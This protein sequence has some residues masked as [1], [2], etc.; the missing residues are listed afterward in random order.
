MGKSQHKRL[1]PTLVFESLAAG[2]P[3]AEAR[4]KALWENSPQRSAFSSIAYAQGAA[5]AFGLRLNMHLVSRD[6]IDEAGAFIWWRQRLGTRQATLPPFTQYSAV[7][8]RKTPTPAAINR[9]QAPLEALLQGLKARYKGLLLLLDVADPRPAQWRHWRV[10]PLFTYRLDPA[11]RQT[12]WSTTTRRT[13]RKYGRVFKTT[14]S[15]D[16]AQT[17]IRLCEASYQRHGRKLPASEG[18]LLRLIEHLGPSV[19][20]F[21]TARPDAAHPEA[22]LAVLHDGRTAHYW[23]AGST[24]GPSMT[25]LIG[26]V[27]ELLHDA[28]ITTFD[29]V[30]ANTA[31]IAEFKR[32]FGG[33]LTQYFAI[34]TPR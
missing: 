24:K 27:L 19:R 20:C 28:G 29:M 2:D 6:G 16:R 1:R 21:V 14:E 4:W 22:G 26:H 34:K 30:G 7:V 8:T 23:V 9:R 15:Q 10:S 25:V 3:A 33:E 5:A 17:I 18:T 11:L 12:P 31:S 13:W 32:Q